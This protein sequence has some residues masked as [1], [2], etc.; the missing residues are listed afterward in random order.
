[1][2]ENLY[3]KCSFC[4]KHKDEVKKLIVGNEVAICNECVDLCQNL[5][6]DDETEPGTKDL[7]DIDPQELKAYLDQYVIGQDRAKTVLSVAIANHY[8]RIQHSSKDLEI[9]KAN[10]LMLGPTGS[11]KTL[12]AK[13][14]ARYLDVPFVIAD[15]TSLTEAGYVGD[16]VES[17]ISRLFAASGGSI[18]KT[19]RGIVFVDEIDK[20]SR[21]SESQSITRDVSGEGVQQALLKLV[22]GTKCRV[23]PTGGRKHPSGETIEIDTSNILFI[24]GGAFVGLDNIVKGRVKG[25]SIGFGAELSVITPDQLADVTPD[26]LVRFGLIPEFVG[27]FPSW[28][29]LNE[30][31]KADLLRILQDVKHNY[32]SQYHWLFERDQVEL[33]FSAESLDLI[34]ERTLKNKTGARGLHSE[35]ERVL[36]PHMFHLAQYR[37]QGITTVEIGVDQVNLPKELK[38]VNG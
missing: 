32:V 30:L 18:E 3:E 34:A 7:N 26:D 13:T 2:A 4:N 19:Q 22:E 10:I 8:K 6:T 35:L 29:A 24:A 17:L 38:Q 27:R 21:R 12:L 25:T 11:G 37:K 15:A 28:V 33:K 5:L 16:D 31:T 23:T 9:D 36:L 14:V 20:I 1:M